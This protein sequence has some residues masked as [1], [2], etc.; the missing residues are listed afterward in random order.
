MPG[1]DGIPRRKALVTTASVGSALVGLSGVSAGDDGSASVD[2]DRNSEYILDDEYWRNENGVVEFDH[3]DFDEWEITITDPDYGSDLQSSS[4][5]PQ[6]YIGDKKNAT[7]ET[8][9]PVQNLNDPSAET[10][11]APLFD[12]FITLAGG[13]IPDYVP[14]IGGSDWGLGAGVIFNMSTL[15]VDIELT[16]SVGNTEVVLWA[17]EIGHKGSDGLCTSFTPSNFPV[18]V[19]PCVDIGLDGDTLH[20]GGSVDLCAPPNDPCP[21]IS[22]QY[23]LTGIGYSEEIDLPF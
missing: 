12:T 18:E 4:V 19:T 1:E 21:G 10:A 6:F 22:C 17:W 8:G 5:E 16:F 23:C 11:F 15:T 3:A 20:I 13:T 9:S 7:M 14:G 2:P